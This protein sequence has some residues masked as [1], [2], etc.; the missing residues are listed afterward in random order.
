VIGHASG[1]TNEGVGTPKETLKNYASTLEEGR[2]DLVALYF[3]YDKKLIDMGLIASLDAGKT[4]Y[5]D[6]IKNGLMLQLRRLEVGDQV[7]EAHMRNRQLIAK[8]VYE[9]GKAENVIEKKTKAGKTYFVVNNY[10]KLRDLFGQLLRELQRIKSE[11]DYAAGKALVET[12]AVEVD[13]ELHQEV[14]ERYKALDSAPYGGFINPKLV[15]VK[16]NGK[17]VDVKVEYPN[18]FKEQMLYYGANYSFLPVK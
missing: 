15:P 7:E 11:G 13:P 3:L 9:K 5:D 6:Y 1:K 8:W 4:A 17:I 10:E 2:A 16:E 12:Y 14:I 18:D